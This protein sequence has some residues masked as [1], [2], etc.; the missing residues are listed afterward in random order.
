MPPRVV[1][2]TGRAIQIAGLIGFFLGV[3]LA[4]LSTRPF[5]LSDGFD[6]LWTRLSAGFTIVGSLGGFFAW[7]L[8]W[9]IE[10]QSGRRTLKLCL[11]D[12]RRRLVL[13]GWC[14]VPALLVLVAVY[15]V[16]W[17]VLSVGWL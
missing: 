3:P 16:V 17:L 5:T 10:I 11:A 8:C 13:S 1:A 7:V 12:R 14:V 6:G 15:A 2:L 4:G 9:Q